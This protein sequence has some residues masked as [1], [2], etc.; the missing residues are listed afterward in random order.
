MKK[1]HTKIVIDIFSKKVLEDEFF[2]HDGEVVQCKGGGSKTESKPL[3]LDTYL[4][5]LYKTGLQPHYSYL[6]DQYK[7]SESFE[8][9]LTQNKSQQGTLASTLGSAESSLGSLSGLTKSLLTPEAYSASMQPY[10][11][12]AYQGIGYSGMPS[13]TYADKTLAEA[14]QQGYMAN[15]GN[16]LGASQAEQSQMSQISDLVN[17][18]NTLTGQEYTAKTEPLELMKAIQ[19]GRYGQ[20]VSKSTTSS[21]GGLLGLF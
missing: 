10:L 3:D 19:L 9:W 11:N 16:I 14:I 7:P 8:D 20:G 6:L 5:G 21:G 17:S 15:L 18:L 13:G 12:K 4:K 2:W 1:V